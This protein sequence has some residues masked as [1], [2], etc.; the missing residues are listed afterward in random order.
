VKALQHG[1]ELAAK[2]AEPTAVSQLAKPDI[3]ARE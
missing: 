3:N 2:A 1:Q